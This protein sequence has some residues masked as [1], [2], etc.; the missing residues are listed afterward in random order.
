MY[1]HIDCLR[2]ISLAHPVKYWSRHRRHLWDVVTVRIFHR[3]ICSSAHLPRGHFLW[4]SSCWIAPSKG[5]RYCCHHLTVAGMS[6]STL[7][8]FWYVIA[9]YVISNGY[10]MMNCFPCGVVSAAVAAPRCSSCCCP[11]CRWS[12]STRRFCSTGRLLLGTF[13]NARG[14]RASAFRWQGFKKYDGPRRDEER[15]RHLREICRCPDSTQTEHYI[16]KV[17]LD[18]HTSDIWGHAEHKHFVQKV[19][20]TT[21]IIRRVSLLT[22][23][24]SIQRFFAY[25]TESPTRW[26]PLMVRW[27]PASTH[28]Q[29]CNIQRRLYS[30]HKPD[31]SQPL[32]LSNSTFG[33]FV[34]QEVG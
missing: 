28:I 30:F 21:V 12:W 33:G 1:V 18:T 25:W 7:I 14:G 10:A 2:T 20:F 29:W 13:C 11:S 32:T 15:G 24:C 5:Y 8:W 27:K 31:R 22:A 16:V 26:A 6:L 4:Q 34:R 17:V 9:K 3:R 19:Q 23:M